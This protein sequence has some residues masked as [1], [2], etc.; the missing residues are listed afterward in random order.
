MSLCVQ[1]SYR[2]YLCARARRYVG[3]GELVRY[4]PISAGREFDRNYLFIAAYL[5]R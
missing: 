1:H 4:T 3:S 2:E 5:L